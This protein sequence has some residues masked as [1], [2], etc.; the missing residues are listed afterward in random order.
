MDLY[1]RL[2][3]RLYYWKQAIDYWC[4][5]GIPY[6]VLKESIVH[7]SHEKSDRFLYLAASTKEKLFQPEKG[8][9]KENLIRCL[10]NWRAQMEYKKI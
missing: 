9:K 10:S 7:S 6:D 3:S 2:D 4:P 1:S 8:V 5:S